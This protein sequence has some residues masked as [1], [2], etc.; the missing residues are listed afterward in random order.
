[1]AK[2]ESGKKNQRSGSS[3][4]KKAVSNQSTYSHEDRVRA[5]TAFRQSGMSVSEFSESWGVS[6]QTIR[7]WSRAFDEG[8]ESALST[9][10]KKNGR[11]KGTKKPVH[12]S[13]RK[14]VIV[15]KE[16]YPFFGV[17]RIQDWCRRAFGLGISRRTV[18]ATLSESGIKPDKKR[19]KPKAKTIRFFERAKPMQMWQSDITQFVCPRTDKKVFLCVF[20]DDCTRYIVGWAVATNPTAELVMNAYESGVLRYGRP[21]EVLT[22]QGRQYA[23]WRGK[24]GFQK[25]LKQDGVQHVLSRSHHPETLGKCERLWKTIQEEFWS[26]VEVVSVEDAGS[27]LEH[28]FGYYNFSRPHQSLD[29]ATPAD[30]FFGVENAMRKVIEET[31]QRNAESIALEERPRQPFYLAAQVGDTQLS[32]AAER[33]GLVVS[34]G[35]ETKRMAYEDLGDAITRIAQISEQKTAQENNESDSSNSEPVTPDS[36][37]EINLMPAVEKTPEVADVY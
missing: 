24:T 17:Q 8:G 31:V 25:K 30:R 5:V 35:D 13:I 20:L 11:P 4:G 9:L 33:G 16:K 19:R 22:D 1:M 23:S 29:K 15:T 36:S 14:A 2:K 18:E 32:V 3:K 27:R 10:G 34:T 12:D 21:A 26:R 7:N 6:D 28:W 37:E